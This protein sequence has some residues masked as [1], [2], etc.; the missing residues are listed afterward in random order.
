MRCATP[1]RSQEGGT[2]WTVISTTPRVKHELDG[3]TTG[4]EYSFRVSVRTHTGASPM[5]EVVSQRAA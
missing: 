3:L 4:K 2:N 5:S 1:W